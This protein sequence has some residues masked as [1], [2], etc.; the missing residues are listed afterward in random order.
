MITT[1]RKKWS[2]SVLLSLLFVIYTRANSAEACHCALL[3]LGHNESFLLERSRK[4][5][6]ERGRLCVAP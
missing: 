5:M 2:E 1:T 4:R 6:R 3:A